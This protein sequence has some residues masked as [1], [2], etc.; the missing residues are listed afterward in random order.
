MYQT[1]CK[2]TEAR[3]CSG[4][5]SLTFAG[6]IVNC[7]HSRMIKALGLQGTELDGSKTLR[8][9]LSARNVS[10]SCR[11]SSVAEASYAKR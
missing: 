4:E 9:R 7:A 6:Q 2:P 11:D 8:F 1:V 3:G 10:T 5:V